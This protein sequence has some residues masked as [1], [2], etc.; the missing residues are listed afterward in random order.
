MERKST[1]LIIDDEEGIR[2]SCSQILAKCG[3]EVIQSPDGSDGIEKVTQKRPDLVLLDLKMPGMSGIE[4]L[5][6]IKQIEP[7]TIVI[8][9]TGFATIESAVEAIKKGA[10]DFLPKPFKGNELKVIV[11]R[12]LEKRSLLIESAQLREEKK[13]LEKNFASLVSHQLRAPLVNIQQYFEVILHGAVGEVNEK[14]EGILRKQQ[15]NVKNLLELIDEWLGMASIDNE[16]VQKRLVSVDLG[17]VFQ[18]IRDTL[19]M[20]ARNEQV[21]L[22]ID[23]SGDYPP[24]KGVPQ[25]I[26]EALKNLVHNGIKY[27]T[28]GGQV[29]LKAQAK[30]RLTMIQ[31][32]DNGIGMDEESLPFIFDEFY[33]V[34]KSGNQKKT[35]TGLGLAIVKK[36]IAAHSGSISVESAPGKGTS[37]TILLPAA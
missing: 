35:G 16:V 25:L 1:I 19:D 27:N 31:V 32:A 11:A 10:Y 12:G 6:K 28:P 17:E 24:V 20:V 3:H 33:R 8:V 9:I 37:F 23:Q 36:I 13:R 4:V 30:G 22:I 26:E 15:R 29:T 7:D 5:E 2:D 21:S 18:K 34:N 14:Q